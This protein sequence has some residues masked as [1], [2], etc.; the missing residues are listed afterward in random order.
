VISSEL[1]STGLSEQETADIK[2][3]FS[4][5]PQVKKVLLYGSRAKGNFRP[6]SD[7][8]LSLVGNDIDLSVQ[9]EIE[10]ELDDLMLPYK[11]DISVYH[12]IKDAGLINH[13]DRVGKLIYHDDG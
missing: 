13:I 11:F 3:V 4:R 10:L 8:D 9:N 2:A 6:A 12:K 1:N 5:Y 7:I